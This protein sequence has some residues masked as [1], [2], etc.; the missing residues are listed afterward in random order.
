MAQVS[1]PLS[2]FT[3]PDGLARSS[4]MVQSGPGPPTFGR[5]ASGAA[6]RVDLQT[7]HVN[8]ST[9]GRDR[10]ACGSATLDRNPERG[11]HVGKGDHQGHWIE[12][13]RPEPGL[14][15]KSHSLLRNGVDKDRPDTGDAGGL[16][17][18]QYG[19]A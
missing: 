2:T 14:A 11:F 3:R 19:V 8:S 4:R 10:C 5:R 9:Q 18:A 17:S 6:S 15:V 12:W 1:S 7:T 13:G 16:A